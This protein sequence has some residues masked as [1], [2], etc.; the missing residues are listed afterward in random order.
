MKIIV[1]KSDGVVLYAVNAVLQIRDD[2]IVCDNVIIGD[3]SALTADV[4][5]A[6]VPSGF[7][8][9]KFQYLDGAW[10]ENPTYVFPIENTSLPLEPAA[11]I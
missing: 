4:V 1:R 7:V 2:V 5:E 3:H 9:G 10:S 6:D 11:Q 8:G